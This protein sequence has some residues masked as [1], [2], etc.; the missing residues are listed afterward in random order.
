MSY[1]L[2][3]LD[4]NAQRNTPLPV[5]RKIRDYVNAGAAVVGEKRAASPSNTDN[6]AEFK[7]IA[8]DLWGRVR[9]NAP[10]AEARCSPG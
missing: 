7:R 1:R 2:L 10:W 5:L 4:R 6:Q 9:A 8:D 3:A